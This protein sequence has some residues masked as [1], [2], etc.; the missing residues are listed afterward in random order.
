MVEVASQDRSR[1]LDKVDSRAWS[2]TTRIPRS[3]RVGHRDNFAEPRSSFREFYRVTSRDLSF[4]SRSS[5]SSSIDSRCAAS[6]SRIDRDRSRNRRY[7][8]DE[9]L[10]R[11]FTLPRS[12]VPRDRCGP[13]YRDGLKSDN[14]NKKNRNGTLADT[15][16]EWS[17]KI[18][19]GES[20]EST[21]IRITFY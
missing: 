6:T 12:G 17:R 21:F 8:V 9:M 14:G 4:I 20:N 11:S 7:C 3:D 13:V 15:S 19:Y 16:R 2:R 18:V 5:L 1:Y 10:S